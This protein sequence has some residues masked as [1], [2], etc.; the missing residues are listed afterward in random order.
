[1]KILLILASI[2]LSLLT[3]VQVEAQ[4]MGTATATSSGNWNAGMPASKAT[5]SFSGGATSPN[6]ACLIVI[7]AR[8]HC[9]YQ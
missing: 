3:S 9:N 6:D 8:H 1:M 4:C 7:P 5:W 2:S